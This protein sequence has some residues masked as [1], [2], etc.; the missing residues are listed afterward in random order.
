MK[1]QI[2]RTTGILCKLCVTFTDLSVTEKDEQEC[3][4]LTTGNSRCYLK[5]STGTTQ[6]Q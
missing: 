5:I 6:K 1:K 2:N 3:E 4:I